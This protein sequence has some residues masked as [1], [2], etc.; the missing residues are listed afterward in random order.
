[1]RL[2]NN[3]DQ[4][5]FENNRLNQTISIAEEQLSSLRKNSE[6]VREEILEAKK[7]LREETNHSLSNL[8]VK[9]NFYDLIEIG[10]YAKPISHKISEYEV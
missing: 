6:K 8:W 5:D 9:D 3:Y 2:K 10:Q 7:Q 4:L 1:M